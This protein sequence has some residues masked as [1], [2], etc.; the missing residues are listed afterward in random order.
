VLRGNWAGG[1]AVV[2]PLTITT[3]AFGAAYGAGVGLRAL[4]AAKRSLR[5]RFADAAITVVAGLAGAA[6]AGA[7]GVA[8]AFAA[9]A[10]CLVPVWWW[11]FRKALA[12]HAAV[13]EAEP[14]DLSP[15]VAA[16]VPS[17]EPSL[18][19]EARA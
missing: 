19:G 15:S 13:G 1:H 4:A 6:V 5:V 11:Q 2:L 3:A 18:D 9:G 16:R 7:G 12:E 10:A 8:W 14:S 17:A